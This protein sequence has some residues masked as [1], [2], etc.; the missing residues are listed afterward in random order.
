M[1]APEGMVQHRGSRRLWGEYW[2]GR[3]DLTG[4][5]TVCEHAAMNEKALGREIKHLRLKAEMTLREFARRLG[6]SPAHQSD[7]EHGRRRPS[8]ELLRKIAEELR[9]VGGDYDSLV[10]L[11]TRIEPEISEWVGRTPAARQML[12]KVRDSK[13]DPEDILRALE[14]ILSRGRG[15]K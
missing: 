14:K 11:D 12:R 3:K 1:R 6:I 10:R 5:R 15:K 13:K 4:V 9:A 8:L 7:I 2:G